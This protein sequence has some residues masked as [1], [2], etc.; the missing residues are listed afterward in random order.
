VRQGTLHGK[1]NKNK[2]PHTTPAVFRILSWNVGGL[3][4]ARVVELKKLLDDTNADVVCLQEAQESAG[5]KL[6]FPGYR[7]FQRPRT[8]GRILGGE[9]KGGGVITLVRESIKLS[10]ITTPPLSNNDDTTEWI[11]V[12]IHPQPVYP[13]DPD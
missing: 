1:N 12:T 13:T 3:S 9:L 6:S 7:I 11:G 5:R 8:R 4:A 10:R 2:R